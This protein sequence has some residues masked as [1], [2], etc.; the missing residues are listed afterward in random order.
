M[1]LPEEGA[2]MFDTRRY[3][4]R[5][6]MPWMAIAIAI[7]PQDALA[8]DDLQSHAKE[9]WEEVRRR[10]EI[11]AQKTEND[12]WIALP[13][14]QRLAAID[15]TQAI[16]ALRPFMTSLEQDLYPSPARRD[17]LYQKIKV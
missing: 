9:R 2:P 7:L 12:V 17:S 16:D 8:G 1:I 10:K 4:S 11:A 3:F 5:G 14:S 6:T 15:P 13:Q